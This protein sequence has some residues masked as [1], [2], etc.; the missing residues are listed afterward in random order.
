MKTK[1]EL[2]LKLSFLTGAIPLVGGWGIFLT[3]MLGRYLNASDFENLEPLGFMWM[4][5]CFFVAIGGLFLLLIY[6]VL[7]RNNLHKKMLIVLTVILINIP[8]VA[9]ILDWQKRVAGREFLKIVN[10]TG[11]GNLRCDILVGHELITSA[12]IHHSDFKVLNFHLYNDFKT[13]SPYQDERDLI[14]V[15]SNSEKEKEIP[16]K[17][18]RYGRCKQIVINE[19][20]TLEK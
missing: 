5:I 8:S 19:D 2:L 11:T 13:F 4:I 6:V 1:G 18:L 16:F 9:I 20:F 10:E 17:E 7:N 14:L 15:I 12:T 3:W